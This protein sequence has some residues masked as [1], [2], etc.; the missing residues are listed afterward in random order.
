MVHS[1]SRIPT[2]DEIYRFRPAD[3]LIGPN[4]ELYRQT[5]YL[6]RPEELNDPAEDNVNVVWHGDDIVWD[7]LIT[8]Y[9]RSLVASSLLGFVFLPGYHVHNDRH[10]DQFV[11]KSAIRLRDSRSSEIPQIL[12]DLKHNSPVSHYEMIR[13]LSKLTSRYFPSSF[14]PSNNTHPIE[15][16]P[17]T[18]SKK[19]GKIL[20]SEWGI[21]SFTKDFT[22]P[23]LWSSYA[24]S[25][26][27]V[28]LVFDRKSLVECLGDSFPDTKVE[29]EDV[30]YER[31]KPEIEFFSNLPR[32]TAYEY[33]NLFTG[34]GGR[35]SPLSPFLPKNEDSLKEAFRKRIYLCRKNILTKHRHWEAEKEVRLFSLF[36]LGREVNADSA[37]YTLQYPI[38]ALKGIIFGNH[39]DQKDRQS[40]LEVILSKHYVSP[41]ESFSFQVASPQPNGTIY[42]TYYE[43]YLGWKESYSYPKPRR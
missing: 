25:H 15:N 36:Y 30:S 35:Q 24:D 6:A 43:P 4:K 13:V 40:I 39:I 14:S 32:M 38:E 5:I 37:E 16:F 28:C 9:L 10:F 20:L 2:P 11:Q 17:E 8:F 23:Y 26:S 19:M 41:M 7:N 31:T 33:E 42:R 27:G 29:L 12:D 22:N 21:A 18:F 34:A 3:A 1:F